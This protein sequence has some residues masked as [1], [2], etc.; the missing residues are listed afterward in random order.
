MSDADVRRRAGWLP[1]QDDLELW[2]EERLD[3]VEAAGAA[4]ELHPVLVELQELL[5]REPLLRMYVERMLVEEPE[6]KPYAEHH[7]ETTDQLLRLMNQLLTTAP[8]FSEK[9]M[10]AT[11]LGAILD[12]AIGTTAG[13]AAFRDPRLN[14]ALKRFLDTWCEFLDSPAS[15]YVLTDQ[16]GGWTSEAAREAIGIERFEHDP[17]AA[18]WGFRSWNHFFTRRFREGQR[19]VAEPDD[20]A[21]VVSPCESVPYAIGRDVQDE[22]SFW[23]KSQPYSLRDL[24]AGDPSVDDFVGGTIWQSYLSATS[25]HRWHS[26]VAGTVVR[27]FNVDGTYYSE[28]DTEGEGATEPSNSQG[29]MA[30]VATRAVIVLEADNPEIGLVAFVPVGMSDVSSCRIHPHVAPGRHLA[31]GEELGYFQFG[32]STVC[33]VLR[34]GVV[35]SFEL[36]AIPEPADP[37]APTPPVVEVCS[38]ILRTR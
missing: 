14:A 10:V 12:W 22:D 33:L 13:F 3:Q 16:P 8:E 4:V 18:H 21:V 35:R 11:P 15:L 9:A 6:G 30:H 28:A 24:L 19:P 32:G 7:V 23:V 27:A 5:A 26:P 36:Q 20:D 38:A 37:A 31:K 1:P 17:D 29:Y 34:P 25:Y 2:L